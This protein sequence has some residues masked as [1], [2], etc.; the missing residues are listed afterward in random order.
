MKQKWWGYR[1]TNGSVQAKP[2]GEFIDQELEDAHESP[3]CRQ[4][5]EPFEAGSREEALRIVGM[6]TKPL[7]DK[8]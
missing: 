7:T 2:V 1:H 8:E 6:R 5:V 3:F 4:V